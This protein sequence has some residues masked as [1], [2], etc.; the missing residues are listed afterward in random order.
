MD[1]QAFFAELAPI[2]KLNP[3][4]VD[5]DLEIFPSEW[6]SMVTLSIIAL[7]DDKFGITIPT[8]EL[9]ACTTIGGLLELIERFA[10]AQSQ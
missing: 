10:G 2:L 7:I 6:D 3:V 5:R 9:A 8:D 4:E 1:R